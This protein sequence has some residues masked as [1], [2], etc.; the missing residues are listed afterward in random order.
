M[1]IQVAGN[2]GKLNRAL[3]HPLRRIAKAVQNAVGQ[4][5]MVGTDAHRAA[6]LPA[7]QNQG[8][9][10]FPQAVQLLA[11]FGV[12]ILPHFKLLLINEIARINTNLLH[13]FGSLHRGIRLEVDIGHQRHM[14]AG[15]AQFPGNILQIGGIRLGLG[16]QADNLAPCLRQLQSLLHAGIRIPRIGRQH[17]LDPDGIGTAHPHIP[18]HDFTGYAARISIRTRTIGRLHETTLPRQIPLSTILQNGKP[19]PANPVTGKT[20][21]VP[22]RGY[23]STPA[24]PRTQSLASFPAFR[25]FRHSTD[26]TIN[27]TIDPI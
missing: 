17:G 7:K 4:G 16:G 25:V 8:R 1:V 15:S 6:M 21:A 23:C 2:L 10:F 11:V 12:G 20:G 5:A 19:F 26:C 22:P 14:A 13:P 18:H 3:H 9:K 27:N 24:S